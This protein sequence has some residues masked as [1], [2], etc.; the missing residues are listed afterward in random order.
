TP[1][2]SP[3]SPTAHPQ[4]TI[5]AMSSLR[6]C[7]F[8]SV[9]WLQD[10]SSPPPA[11]KSWTPPRPSDPA[12]LPLLLAPSSLPS[13]VG[14]PAPL[15]SLI[16]PAPPWSVDSTP[17]AA[18]RRSV[19]LLPRAPPQSPVTPAPP[20]TSGCP[21]RLPE[22]WPLPWPSGSSV[23]PGLIGSRAPPPLAPPPS[24]GPLE[25]PLPGGGST[26]TPLEFLYWFFHMW[27]FL[28]L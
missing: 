15:G 26:V 12:D 21:P 4:P 6:V 24:V 18:P 1:P 22:P 13:P 19:R 17:P 7:Q 28:F 2:L 25:P 16:P 3:D 5:C 10:P 14:P 27:S 20:R 8:P 11:S 23:S 9:L